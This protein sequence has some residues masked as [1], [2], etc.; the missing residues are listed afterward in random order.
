MSLEENKRL[1]RE[2]IKIWTTGD[3]D[4]ADALY[5]SDYV[6]HQH[7]DPQDPRDL[8]GVQAMKTFIKG[9]RQAFPDFRDSIDIQLAEADM[10]ATRFTSMGTHRG[11]FMGLEPTNRELSRTGISI[12]RISEGKIVESWANWDMMGMMQQLDAV[13]APE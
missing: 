13:S 4:A 10:V 5:A 1:A 11:A 6:N 12:D 2:A 7:H 3:L 9:F 8:H